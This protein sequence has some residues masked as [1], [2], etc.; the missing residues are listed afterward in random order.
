MSVG[1]IIRDHNGSVRAAKCTTIRYVIDP[2]VAKALASRQGVEL[3]RELG[4]YA[5]LLEGDAR[6]IVSALEHDGD[7]MGRCGSFVI[8]TSS[9][10]SDF[11]FFFVSTHFRLSFLVSQ[12]C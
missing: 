11:F 9:L 3:C 8:D 10:I 12:I 6:E 2:L 5:I 7:A 1:I 4:I